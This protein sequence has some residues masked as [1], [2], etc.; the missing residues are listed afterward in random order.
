MSGYDDMR[1]ECYRSIATHGKRAMIYRAISDPDNLPTLVEEVGEVARAVTEL[2]NDRVTT[3]AGLIALSAELLQVATM[4][5]DWRVAVEMEL[6][7]RGLSVTW[8]VDA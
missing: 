3:N 2:N 1:E 5:H 6:A 4:A 7:T 8:P